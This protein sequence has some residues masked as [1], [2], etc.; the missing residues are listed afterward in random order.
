MGGGGVIALQR[1][2]VKAEEQWELQKVANSDAVRQ[3][4]AE[5]GEMQGAVVQTLTG[6]SAALRCALPLA[7]LPFHFPST[8]H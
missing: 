3:A 6:L 7:R 1:R 8:K 2:L 4:G 5:I